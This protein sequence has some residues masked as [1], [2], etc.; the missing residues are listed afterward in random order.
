VMSDV[1]VVFVHII[2]L[3]YITSWSLTLPFT[4][5]ALSRIWIAILWMNKVVQCSVFSV[6]ILN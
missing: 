4:N 6:L 5:R 3:H 2:T 1:I